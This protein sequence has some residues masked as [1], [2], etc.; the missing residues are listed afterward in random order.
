[1]RKYTKAKP[2]GAGAMDMAANVPTRMIAAGNAL[3]SGNALF[4]NPEA[5]LDPSVIRDR[6]T[7]ANSL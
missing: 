5:A 3:A 4:P 1:M 6:E 7:A 2:V